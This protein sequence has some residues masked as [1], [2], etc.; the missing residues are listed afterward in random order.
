MLIFLFGLPG[1]GKNYV[2]NIFQE[3]FDFYFHDA[4]SDLTPKFKQF[5]SNGIIAP[6][7]IRDDYYNLLI[8]HIKEL[9]RKHKRIVV[10]DVLLKEKHRKLMQSHFPNAYFILLNCNPSILDS[11]LKERKHFVSKD[12]A[13]KFRSIFEPPTIKHIKFSNNKNGNEG[14]VKQ[15]KDVLSIAN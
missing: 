12:Y 14:I 2:G 1:S 9:Y 3:E 10:A 7:E 4:D 11:R 13:I 8:S 5:I 6:D 15:I